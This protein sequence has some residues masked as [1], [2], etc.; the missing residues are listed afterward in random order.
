MKLSRKVIYR[1]L[2]ID[3]G[4]NRKML[5][6]SDNLETQAYCHG[7][8]DAAQLAMNWI[9]AK[10]DK[11]E[12]TKEQKLIVIIECVKYFTGLTCDY[13]LSTERHAEFMPDGSPIHIALGTQGQIRWDNTRGPI[14][15]DGPPEM[16]SA[17]LKGA[18]PPVTVPIW[19]DT[20]GPRGS[21]CQ[22]WDGHTS[23]HGGVDTKGKWLTWLS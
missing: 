18:N 14:R 5:E 7:F 16:I 1:S 10:D 11:L 4:R 22:F 20:S 12:S 21:C 19:C 17:S 15:T 13:N 3:Q 23:D 8:I 6:A 9:K 2:Q